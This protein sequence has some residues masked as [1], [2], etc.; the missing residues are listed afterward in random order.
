[1]LR[2]TRHLVLES[3]AVAIALVGVS[4]TPSPP[5]VAPTG[6]TGDSAA[7][8][9]VF[10]LCGLTPH[11]APTVSVPAGPLTQTT[12][13]PVP[14]K[15]TR[16]PVVPSV[17][18]GPLTQ[19]TPSR[20]TTKVAQPT[21]GA[22]CTA[23]GRPV[24]LTFAPLPFL[25]GTSVED[26]RT[27]LALVGCTDPAAGPLRAVALVPIS[28]LPAGTV[29][30]AAGQASVDQLCGSLPGTGLR[31]RSGAT[32]GTGGMPALKATMDSC[33][34]GLGGGLGDNRRPVFGPEMASSGWGFGTSVA[35]GVFDYSQTLTPDQKIAM[36]AGLLFIV[37]PT[38]YAL[39]VAFPVAAPALLSVGSE[40]AEFGVVTLGVGIYEKSKNAEPTGQPPT[41]DP[42]VPPEGPA[43]SQPGGGPTTGGRTDPGADP[44]PNSCMRTISTLISC[45]G[46]RDPCQDPQ[47]A[48]DAEAIRDRACRRDVAYVD[49]DSDF[50][51][52]QN[53]SEQDIANVLVSVC[54]KSMSV[55][56]PVPGEPPCPFMYG[57]GSSTQA[58][59]I[60]RVCTQAMGATI[61]CPSRG[62]P[63]TAGPLLPPICPIG[64]GTGA[65][66]CGPGPETGPPLQ[67]P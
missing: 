22:A 59:S 18:T 24:R 66:D 41:R 17:P 9:Q 39:S 63:A 28:R 33:T 7:P 65:R 62:D 19:T 57:A 21:F 5:T 43:P 20:P 53:L 29:P 61:T 40:V 26:A 60:P 37:L 8:V 25:P 48:A 50:C 35:L 3:L 16:P 31:G 44:A 38:M 23:L 14:T 2:H 13:N 36:G 54:Q 47:L 12:P 4:C 49:P 58:S 34:K 55:R 30:G 67:R 27:D 64:A 10:T 51:A 32:L 45:L 52:G 56:R 15:G 42:S 11:A 6:S 1:M 46:Q